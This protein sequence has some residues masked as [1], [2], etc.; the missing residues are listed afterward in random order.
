MTMFHSLLQYRHQPRWNLP[1]NLEI[2]SQ[3]CSVQMRIVMSEKKCCIIPQRW[4]SAMWRSDFDCI[5]VFGYNARETKARN[6][7]V[8]RTEQFSCMMSENK[9]RLSYWILGLSS[10][11]G[12]SSLSNVFHILQYH[13][14]C[15]NIWVTKCFFLKTEYTI[16][17][18][19]KD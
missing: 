11:S 15:K 9:S 10:K 4:F 14:M 8:K 7:S 3:L 6:E 16:E 1:R 17:N 13:S 12:F 19:L 18:Y 2:V 5:L